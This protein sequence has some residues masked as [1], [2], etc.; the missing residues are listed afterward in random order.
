ML[1]V[2]P[3]LL[4]STVLGRRLGLA[5]CLLPFAATLIA[6]SALD[7]I[8]HPSLGAGED[9]NSIYA[10]VIYALAIAAGLGVAAGATLRALQDTKDDD[11][12]TITRV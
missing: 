1:E 9:P 12:P 5:A 7:A 3:I 11:P 6:V 8:R 10:I 2:V 4:V